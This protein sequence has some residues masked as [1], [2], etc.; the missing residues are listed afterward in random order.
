MLVS[1]T[2]DDG[3]LDQYTEFYPI[4]ANYG[5]RATFYIVTSE[6]DAPGRLSRD[7]IKELYEAGNEI[8]SHSHTHPPLT[9]LSD[10]ELDF[11][12]RKSFDVLKPFNPR[13][14][15]Y[16]F[17][18]YDGRVIKFAKRYYEAARAYMEMPS[19]V[20]WNVGEEHE[21]FKLKAIALDHAPA[22]E[23]PLLNV[24]PSLFQQILERMVTEN[25]QKR[26][27][28]ILV[29]HGTFTTGP[30]RI[31]WTIKKRLVTR[32]R[33]KGFLGFL[34]PR[35]TRKR[36]RNALY[37]FKWL[38]Q[39]LAERPICVQNISE[40]LETTLELQEKSLEPLSIKP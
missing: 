6:I 25:L 29:L 9:H 35:T 22:T 7:Q 33:I 1:L 2:F 12:L 38:C 34:S 28:L 20:E 26:F 11:E 30:E 39:Y 15:A 3:N 18:V 27:W 17:G 21:R 36:G 19:R 16:P 8:G 10:R 5:L 13:T 37:N 14:L 40:A 32:R 24:S 4:M 31:V 23:T